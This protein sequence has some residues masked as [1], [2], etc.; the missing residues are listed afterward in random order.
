[1]NNT[2]P[3]PVILDV[4]TGI[5]DALAIMLAVRHPALDLRA[6]TCVGG[7][8]PVEQVVANTLAVLALAGATDVPVAAGMSQPLIEP[9][10]HASYVHGANGLA[11]LALPMHDLTVVRV[12]AVELL[13]RTIEDS[14]EP[15]TLIALAPLTNIAVF[16]RMYPQL[17][18]KIERIVLMGGSIGLGNAT[19]SAEFNVWHDPEAAQIVLSSGIPTTMYGLEPFYGVTCSA[20]DIVELCDS[21]DPAQRFA[22][23]LLNHLTAMTADE[24]RIAVA[25]SAAIGDAGTVCAVI[26]PSGIETR[27]APVSVALSP[28]ETRGQTVVDLRSGLGAG[29]EV[30]VGERGHIDVVTAVDGARFRALFLK[31]LR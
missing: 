6:V 16:L 30:T 5:D 9:A 28:G 22:G 12:H 10:Q 18:D 20:S 23:G 31:A 17:A 25:G 19:A 15:L 11:D 4:D 13:R 8:V 3:T 26:D 24:E 29:G 1:M 7:N 14:V 21:L 27:R 2:T